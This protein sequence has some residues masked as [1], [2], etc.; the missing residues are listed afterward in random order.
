MKKKDEVIDPKDRRGK[1]N[2]MSSKI[3]DKQKS[4]VRNHIF[5]KT[6]LFMQTH[7]SW[8]QGRYHFLYRHVTLKSLL[9]YILFLLS[10]L[11]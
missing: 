3:S 2:N 1:H 8:H 5:L 7:I 4:S 6:N 9:K 10:T 11:R